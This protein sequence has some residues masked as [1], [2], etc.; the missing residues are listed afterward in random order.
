MQDLSVS[1]PDVQPPFDLDQ[2]VILSGRDAVRH[3][4]DL[5]IGSPDHPG[6]HN[7][8]L[9]AVDG[10]FAHYTTLGQQIE[11]VDVLLDR[12]GSAAVT[13]RGLILSDAVLED[14]RRLLGRELQVLG[15]GCPIGMFVVNALSSRLIVTV[16]MP[17]ERARRLTFEEGALVRDDE[18][19][20]TR[21]G[22][23]DIT[24]RFWPDVALLNR[25]VLDYD[26]LVEGIRSL[27]ATSPTVSIDIVNAYVAAKER[28]LV[29]ARP[30][31]VPHT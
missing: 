11:N 12:N 3:R 14:N 25:G 2:V 21:I 31:T 9:L 13:S 19:D 30:D 15:T 4:P 29:A 22:E 18:E 16:R 26:S 7:L 23:G 20:A 5:Y 17:R 10:L 24:L 28:L 6:L 27:A 8:L 1:A